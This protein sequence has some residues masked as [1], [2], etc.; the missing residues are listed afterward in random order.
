MTTNVRVNAGRLWSSLMEM[1]ETAIARI[2]SLDVDRAACI[3]LLNS[4]RDSV[5][6]RNDDTPFVPRPPV[7]T[8]LPNQPRQCRRAQRMRASPR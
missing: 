3:R 6:S 4:G 1:A 7:N 8:R 5:L 2:A